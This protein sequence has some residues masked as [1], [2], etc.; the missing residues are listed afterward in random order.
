MKKLFTLMFVVS[1]TYTMSASAGT[2][3]AIG[4][5][6]GNTKYSGD[7]LPS[8]GDVGN[9]L[10]YGAVLEISTLPVIDLELQLN[11]ASTEFTYTFDV[12]GN[13]V[14]TTFDFRDV[15]GLAI[16]KK[17]LPRQRLME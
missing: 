12:A 3:V 9:A 16:V 5:K 1:M 4:A 17:N 6:V 13:P 7:I 11:Y 15:Y 2:G 14:S 10:T 8:S